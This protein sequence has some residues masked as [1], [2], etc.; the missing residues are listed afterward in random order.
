MTFELTLEKFYLEHLREFRVMSFGMARAVVT[1]L[2]K[3]DK[4][5]AR[6]KDNIKSQL[7]CDVTW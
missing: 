4:H 5:I 7:Y 3:K 2:A 6:G 1:M